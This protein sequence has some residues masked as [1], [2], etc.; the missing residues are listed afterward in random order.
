MV[1]VVVAADVSVFVVAV[2]FVGG[3]LIAIVVVA[4]VVVVVVGGG[5]AAEEQGACRTPGAAV[6]SR[7]VENRAGGSM[8]VF[9]KNMPHYHYHSP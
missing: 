9:L 4:V 2:V 3:A 1:A 5:A 7:P 8:V 6:R